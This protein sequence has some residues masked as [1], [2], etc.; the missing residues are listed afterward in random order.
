[1]VTE[2]NGR[3]SLFAELETLDLVRDGPTKTFRARHVPTG[4]EVFLHL[5][6]DSGDASKRFLEQLKDEVG[7]PGRTPVLEAGESGG[8]SYVVTEVLDDFTSFE[9]WRENRSQANSPDA[10][11]SRIREH[12]EGGRY[13]Q[14]VQEAG[15]AAQQHPHEPRF[16]Q[17]AEGV[18]LFR[19]GV[20]LV[21]AG[22]RWE[23]LD[24]LRQADEVSNRDPFLHKALTVALFDTARHILDT[25]WP[26]AEELLREVLQREPGHEG[27]RELLRQTLGSVPEVPEAAAAAPAKERQKAAPAAKPARAPWWRQ[28]LA[29]GQRWPLASALL[30]ASAALTIIAAIHLTRG[31]EQAAAPPAA[32][33]FPV[34][35]TAEPPGAEIAVEGEVC[36][37]SRCTVELEPGSY[38]VRA[39]LSG[40]RPASATL[41]VDGAAG[42][43]QNPLALDLTPLPVRIRILSDLDGG[44]VSLG[45][46]VLGELEEGGLE[47]EAPP[48][49]GGSRL[50]EITSGRRRA[51]IPFR[52]DAGAAP[53]LSS[54]IET[55]DLRAAV[56]ASFGR[57]AVVYSPQAIRAAAVDGEE[58][59]SANGESGDSELL[60]A[61][62]A[63]GAHELDIKTAAGDQKLIFEAG[64]QPLLTVSLRSDR[65]AGGLQVMT[66]ADGATIYI[67][68]RPQRRRTS[69][70]RAVLWLR[71]GTYTVRAEKEGFKPSA[72]RKVAVR[73]GEMAQLVLRLEPE[74]QTAALEVRNGVPGTEV[75]LDGRLIGHVGDQ[76]SFLFDQA[77]PGVRTVTLRETAHRSKQVQQE[78]NKAGKVVI[79]GRLENAMGELLVEVQPEGVDPRLTLRREGQ[80]GERPLDERRLRLREGVYSVKASAEGYDDFV[81]TVR[82][83]AGASKTAS[84]ILQPATK[85]PQAQATMADWEA[86]GGWHRHDELLL[87]RGGGFVASPNRPAYGTYLVTVWLQKGKRL[88]WAVRFQ[89]DDNHL[90]FQLSAGRL[91]RYA[92]VRGDKGRTLRTESPVSLDGFVS[93]RIEVRPGSVVHKAL[94]GGEW[95]TLDEWNNP[96]A[97]GGPGRFAFRLR[98]RDQIALSHFTFYPLAE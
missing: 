55:R 85:Q 9:A 36:G 31:D 96:P 10:L 57:E 12:L 47:V 25:D 22:E 17:L 60:L 82:V 84:L 64:E 44:E 66:E 87:R 14:A 49:A 2:V 97:S 29:A 27:A 19:E 51:R 81:A 38:L 43:S 75:L 58:A 91:E 13:E 94:A 50:L 76:G 37:T 93:M 35:V 54:P 74:T 46:E 63:P 92:A 26:G 3:M 7:G 86:A 77:P 88:E 41:E 98:G 42:P 70:G 83:E 79:D 5:L 95:R 78:F 71:P 32:F 16:R 89:D 59:A 65:N 62:L 90:H 39:T 33:V 80:A 23:A 21:R 48:P 8:S 34:E 20:G 72:S 24:R 11:L 15:R 67:N 40:F 56:V 69:R 45:G 18:D 61:S 6:N 68:G 73:K 28:A 1:M 52:A 30:G 53:E 4:R